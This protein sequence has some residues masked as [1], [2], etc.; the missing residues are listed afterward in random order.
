MEILEREVI[1]NIC[2]IDV[3]KLENIDRKIRIYEIVPI[4]VIIF[5]V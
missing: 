2:F 1:Y 5:S 4:W 3:V